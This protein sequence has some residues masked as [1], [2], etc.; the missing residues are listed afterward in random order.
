MCLPHLTPVL[1]C[2][3]ANRYWG[4]RQ[5]PANVE[6]WPQGKI[7]AREVKVVRGN[8]LH[9][10]SAWLDAVGSAV[11]HERTALRVHP[12]HLLEYTVTLSAGDDRATFG[13][14][15]EGFFGIRLADALRETEGAT[16]R[17]A[18]GS[19]GCDPCYGRHHDWVDYSGSCGGQTVGAAL[20][21]HP[22]NFR[23]A[24]YHV[25]AYGLFTISPFGESAYTNGE[26]SAAP[27]VLEP[28]QSLVLRYGLFVHDG[29][30]VEAN[31]ASVYASFAA[32]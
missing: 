28:R 24:F 27:V 29:D 30:A 11:L 12:N 32:S 21:D 14:T 17:S 8:E 19:R 25:R 9:Y 23:R 4:E 7:E 3:P 31:V 1:L 5:I 13:D 22:S 10:H 26:R 2:L 16:V 15:K 20:F 6:R 18:D